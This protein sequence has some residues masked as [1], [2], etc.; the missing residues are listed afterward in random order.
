VDPLILGRIGNT[1]RFGD[2]RRFR[3]HF[4][5][6][7]FGWRFAEASTASFHDESSV[8]S[9]REWTIPKDKEATFEVDTILHGHQV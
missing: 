8:Y 2:S 3:C 9:S 7:R 5:A 4:L 6:R 1:G